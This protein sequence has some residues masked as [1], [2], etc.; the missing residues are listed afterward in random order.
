MVNLVRDIYSLLQSEDNIYFVMG[1]WLNLDLKTGFRK[2]E[3]DQDISHLTNL[4]KF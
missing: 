4:K 3:Q 2:I 1:D